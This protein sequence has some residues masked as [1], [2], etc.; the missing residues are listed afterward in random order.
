[1]NHSACRPVRCENQWLPQFCNVSG[2]GRTADL[3]QWKGHFLFGARIQDKPLREGRLVGTIEPGNPDN[4]MLGRC[5]Q[6][7]Q[8]TSEFRGAVN[9]DG[10]GGSASVYGADFNPS[11][12]KSVLKWVMW[13]PF[14]AQIAAIAPGASAF[15]AWASPRS[16]RSR[17]PP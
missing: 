11:N 10:L 13:T 2:A 12:T 17:P 4:Q 7:P 1:M 3:I 14:L 9:V 15:S 6:N 8:F 16:T 5:G